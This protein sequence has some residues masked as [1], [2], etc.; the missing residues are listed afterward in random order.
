MD[1]I[2]YLYETPTSIQTADK[3]PLI[4]KKG[5]RLKIVKDCFD[6]HYLHELTNHWREGLIEKKLKVGDVVDV[7]GCWKNFYGSYIKCVLNNE[8]YD[9]NP[10]NLTF[11]L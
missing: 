10:K 6:E 7:L 4:C 2:G 9:V 3:L 11:Y 5:S 1:K 8:T